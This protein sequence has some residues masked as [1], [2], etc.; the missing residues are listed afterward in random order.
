MDPLNTQ[1]GTQSSVQRMSVLDGARLLAARRTAQA[2]PEAP[3]PAPRETAASQAATA[4]QSE[5]E[6]EQDTDPSTLP[7]VD[8]GETGQEQSEASQEEHSEEPAVE[9]DDGTRLTVREIKELKKGSLRQDDYTRK[10]QELAE[11]RRTVGEHYQTV[12]KAQQV[13]EHSLQS[14]EQ[15]VD[16]QRK[17]IEAAI[18]A[19]PDYT[20]MRSDPEQYLLQ[21]EV[22]ERGL[23]QLREY[24]ARV[25]NVRQAA[26]QTGQLA[27]QMDESALRLK[28]QEEESK[29]LERLP[30]WR[31]AAVRQR[32]LGDMQ[33]HLTKIGLTNEALAGMRGIQDL[34]V[35]HRFVV[36]LRQ[37]VTGA[38]VIEGGAKGGASRAPTLT[39]GEARAPVT[40]RSGQARIIEQARSQLSSAKTRREREQAGTQLLIAQR[41]GNA[42]R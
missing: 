3:P 19:A 11:Q 33:A 6:R 41:R 32:E 12:V 37:A 10:A 40:A 42:G 21:K 31:D 30:R 22:R 25:G 4:G 15:L 14:F 39:S 26:Q 35:D 2:T 1:Q 36:L 16:W 28:A 5:P 18:P 38:S 17:S 20:L 29:V 34:L 7:V 9:L 24:D 8:T 27:G 23:E 13:L